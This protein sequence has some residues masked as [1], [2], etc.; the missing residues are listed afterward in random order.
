M[1]LVTSKELLHNAMNEG[2]AV[3]AFNANCLEMIPALIRAAE[4]EQSPLILQ[5]GKKF[6]EYITPDHLAAVALDYAKKASVPICIHLDHGA[7]IEQAKDCL[8]A[9]FTS[10]MFDGSSL[11]HEEN[12][13]IT[14]QVVEMA[15][16]FHV[17]VEGEIGKVLM[18]EDVQGMTELT[19]LTEP[20]DAADFVKRT[21]ISSVAVAVGNVHRMKRKTANLDFDRIQA[22]R[23]MVDVPL[24]IHGSSGIS[25]EDVKKAVKCGINKVN[26]ATEYNIAFI[27]GAVDFSNS[28]EKEIF[29]MEVLLH[30]M[31]QVTEIARGR[32]HVVGAAG[33]CK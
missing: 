9:G 15:N 17:P 8:D 31:N 16:A 18:D 6:L 30:G 1:S 33:K 21:G 23:K 25:D 32:I 19:D 2:Y 29:P 10:I 7:S 13:K 12:I 5:L 22:I 27:R 26:V 28:H 4:L 3:P 11:P 14:R 24:V 20:E